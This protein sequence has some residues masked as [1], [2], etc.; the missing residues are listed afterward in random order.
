MAIQPWLFVMDAKEQ[1]DCEAVA[2][3]AGWGIPSHEV[4]NELLIP[5]QILRAAFSNLLLDL[6]SS[7]AMCRRNSSYLN[8][9]LQG[10]AN[11]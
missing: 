5:S 7:K 6:F 2:E 4:T 3:C 9:L 1:G 11:I 8:V 10:R